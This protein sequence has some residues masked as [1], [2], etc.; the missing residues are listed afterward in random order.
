MSS[1]AVVDDTSVRVAPCLY[2]FVGHVRTLTV[3]LFGLF[4]AASILLAFATRGP[5]AAGLGLPGRELLIVTSGSMS[6]GFRT[7]D[8]ITVRHV[9]AGE[10]ARLAPGTV[11]TFRPASGRA[12]LITHRII[13]ARITAGGQRVYTTKG[14]ANLSPDTADLDPA[15]I[16]GV[17]DRSIPRLGYV[18]H[19][20]QQ[21]GVMLMF[22]LAALLGSLAAA[23]WPQTAVTDPTPQQKENQ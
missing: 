2:P 13:G 18:L 3:A 5:S 16:V 1:G 7:G 8:A 11:V 22:A 23:T 9:S 14:D 10:A 20:L 12:S 17:L 21:R 6:P 4:A 19:V 15:R